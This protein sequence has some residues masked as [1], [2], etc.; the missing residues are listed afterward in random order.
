MMCHC[1]LVTFLING[2]AQL[3]TLATIMATPSRTHSFD[4]LSKIGP[5]ET[6]QI[7]TNLKAYNGSVYVKLR[8]PTKY[9]A[10][11]A[12]KI[13]LTSPRSLCEEK[14]CTCCNFCDLF[15]YEFDSRCERVQAR[16]LR[17]SGRMRSGQGTSQNW[18]W[19]VA[20]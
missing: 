8:V 12:V 2:T 18:Q 17:S 6:I 15:T 5:A 16:T 3:T 13:R 10:D 1:L 19:C 7:K 9:P 4:T 11:L 14:K 20:A